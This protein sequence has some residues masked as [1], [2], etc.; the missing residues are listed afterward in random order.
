MWRVKRLDD[1]SNGAERKA[2][3]R[4]LGPVQLT[5]LGIGSTIG[6]GIFVLT[7]EAAQQA[8]PGMIISFILAALVCGLATLCYAE[9]AAMVPVSG[10]A[11]AYTYASFGEVWAWAVG[12]ALVLEYAITGSA[13]AV[14]W[15]GYLVGLLAH[16]S[17]HFVIPRSLAN[18][19][20]AG[21]IINLPA[22]II[23]LLVSLLL[24]RGTKESARVNAVFVA[25]KVSILGV[26]IVLALPM[27]KSS[28]FH[29]F[30]PLGV[31][32]I[33]SAS[34]SIFFTFVG[35]D[36]VATAAE[37]TREPQRNVPIGLFGA[38]F[39]V[40]LVYVLV[41]LGVTGAYGAQPLFGAHGEHF[42]PGSHALGAACQVQLLSRAKLPV[43]CSNE[44]LAFVLRQ[45][46]HP[47][48]G[49]LLGFVA[50]LA[51]PSVILMMIYGQTR[52]F[53]VMARDGL[54]PA[55]LSRI[56]PR[57]QTP[58]LV[59]AIT[60]AAVTIAAAFLPVGRLAAIANSGT[61]FA[62]FLVSLG[63]LRLR[64]T[65]PNRSRP[66]HVV[67]VWIVAP[68][69]ALGCIVLY[70]FLSTEAKIVLP[71]WSGIGLVIYLSY[72]IRRSRLAK[73]QDQAYNS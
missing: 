3:R 58:H 36:A 22:V 71:I 66:F 1:F 9:L 67:G 45:T 46:G 65:D 18:G 61:L 44:A 37:E 52:V 60:G 50:F 57:Y 43:V 25:L 56:H 26:F 35:F 70:V 7:S 55:A 51:L 59:T 27:L 73:N 49:N 8:G 63:V 32:G 38:L 54:L 68:L 28:N 53:F 39:A 47:L 31:G 72:G 13:V 41:A 19:P 12:W 11:Y 16:S 23:S 2:L 24:V 5:L 64:R 40:T 48:A 10:S 15:S 21:G 29:P 14:G 34:A 62:F 69:S 33:V 6:T 17:L 30:A 42:L 4:S 20:Y